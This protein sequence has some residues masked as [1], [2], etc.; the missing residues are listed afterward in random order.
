[1]PTPSPPQPPP[2]TPLD[3]AKA[4]MTA[5]AVCAQA[6]TDAILKTRAAVASGTDLVG[7]GAMAATA[8]QA[9]LATQH[10]CEALSSI[11]GGSGPI[12]DPSGTAPPMYEPPAEPPPPTAP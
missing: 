5:A 10:L 2:A 3:L 4:V 12:K 6:T 8:Q 9:A 1:M 7:A 11:Q